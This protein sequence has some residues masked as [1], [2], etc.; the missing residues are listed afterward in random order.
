MSSAG[1]TTRTP[2]ASPS[3][4]VRKT[5]PSSSAGITSPS[6]SDSGPN[7]ALTTAATSAHPTRASTS[8]T[9]SSAGPP[10]RQPAQQ[11]GRHHQRERVADRLTDDGAERRRVV[12]QPQV[13]DHDP[14]PQA[15][16]VQEQH[17]Q[18]QPGGRPQRGHRPV[19]VRELEADPPGEVVRHRNTR[20]GEHVQHQRARPRPPELDD[21]AAAVDR[22]GDG[23]CI[24]GLA[25][26][27]FAPGARRGFRDP[28]ISTAASHAPAAST[29][30]DS[31]M[32]IER[33]IARSAS[34]VERQAD[35]CRP[36]RRSSSR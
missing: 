29:A 12:P 3:V 30:A 26:S 2:A 35:A 33:P 18:A 7:A 23:R 22:A 8:K 24:H 32:R 21:P 9:R 6:R 15:K 4:Q 14:G 27:L 28:Q 31:S 1:A 36:C 34:R 16:A 11:R 13:A 19:Q 17:R 25:A 10:T 5:L 20:D